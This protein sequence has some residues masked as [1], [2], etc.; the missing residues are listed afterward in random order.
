MSFKERLNLSLDG[1]YF[2]KVYRGTMNC[3]ENN[4]YWPCDGLRG[5]G[6]KPGF[7]GGNER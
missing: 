4:V 2:C 7:E 3:D 5:G 1:S 6:M